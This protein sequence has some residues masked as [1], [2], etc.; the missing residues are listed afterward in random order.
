[1]KILCGPPGTGKTYRA[2]REA[3]KVLEP[4]RFA[5]A[6]ASA[7]SEEAIRGLHDRLVAEGRILWVTFHSSYSYEDFIEGY[8]PIVDD[9][10]R[11]AYRVV[12]GP[13]KSLC[14]RA[15]SETDLQ[16]GEQLFDGRGQPAGVVIDKDAGGWTVRSTPAR[17]DQVAA[18]YDRYVPRSVIERIISMGLQ[19][20]I[21][22]I[23]GNG[24][25]DLA[26]FGIDPADPDLPAPVGDETATSRDGL[27]IRRFISVRT[28]MFST[29]DLGNSSHYGAVMRK[30]L[31]LRAP[32]VRSGT[33]VALVIDE[34]NRAEP[35]RVFGELLTLLEADKRRGM[36]EEKRIWLPYSK[37]LFTVPLGISIIG[38]MNTVDR[39]LTALDFAMR[40]RFEFEYIG[41]ETSLLAHALGGIDIRALLG[42]LNSRIRMLL[43]AGH[44]FGHSY[45]MSAKLDAIAQSRGWMGMPD[46]E[47]RSLAR[48]FRTAL[49]PTLA[50]YFHDDWRKI[51]AIAG[52]VRSDAELISLFSSVEADPVFA[53][54][55]PEEYELGESQAPIF[56]DWWDPDGVN[57]DAH[58]FIRFCT[59]LA[60]GT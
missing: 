17:A 41:P 8:R 29:I 45:L 26:D 4:E 20:Q 28:R 22:S 35:S 59:A 21:F 37:E 44:E 58:K 50:E 6:L 15:G 60:A 14:L 40:R 13:F 36:P 43:G 55:L 25:R 57:W 46:A 31:Q 38:T 12:D 53:E 24:I 39:S 54:R 16:I 49:I 10:G 3:A 48:V 19:P 42:R 7:S 11:L 56:A 2:A 52:E 30:L 9:E 27:V 18:Y 33:S 34:I 32:G 5:E 51:R 47:I 23:P 1:M